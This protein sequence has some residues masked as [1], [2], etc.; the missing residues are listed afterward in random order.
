MPG[1]SG[2]LGSRMVNGLVGAGAAFGVRKVLGMA[3]KKAR[4]TEPPS[5]PEDPNAA[6]GEAI[7]WAVLVGVAVAVA[8][9]L[10]IRTI[11]RQAARSITGGTS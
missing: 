11:G 8:R 3:W 2:D 6:L 1:K 10:A 7:V 4:G 5:N 9:I